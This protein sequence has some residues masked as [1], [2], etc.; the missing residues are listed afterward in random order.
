MHDLYEFNDLSPAQQFSHLS[1]KPSSPY[2]GRQTS[3]IRERLVDIH[4]WKLMRDHFHML[5]S[6][7]IENG[8]SLFLRK[9]SGYPRYF[10]ERHGRHGALFAS[11]T[12]KV[13]IEREGHFLYV[14][15]YVHLNALDDFPGA[16][17]WRER[18]RGT[19][20]DLAGAFAHLRDDRWSSYRDYCGIPNFPSILTKSLFESAPG[21]YETELKEYLADRAFDA[22]AQFE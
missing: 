15:H 6:E 1:R 13:L 21:T 3:N 7:R 22:T 8:L 19:V 14:L 2:V 10:N 16:E 18:D 17:H 4:G 11:T 20:L 5:V 12:K 9:M